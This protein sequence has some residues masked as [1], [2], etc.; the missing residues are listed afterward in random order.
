MA[1]RDQQELIYEMLEELGILEVTEYLKIKNKPYMDLNVDRL[2]GNVISMAHNYIQNGD[3]MADPDMTIEIYPDQRRAEALTFQ[4][5][6]VG[7]WQA[8][9]NYDDQGRKVAVRPRLKKELN[10]FL[11]QW[12]RNLKAQGFHL[13]PKLAA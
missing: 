13:Q 4:N 12:L 7:V 11:V 8:V 2:S 6:G 3:V 9:Y 10:S 5:D 1:R